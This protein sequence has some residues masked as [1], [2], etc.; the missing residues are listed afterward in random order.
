MRPYHKRFRHIDRR[1][2]NATKALFA[3]WSDATQRETKSLRWLSEVSEI[4]G[5]PTPRLKL[6]PT[7]FDHYQRDH[8]L[9]VLTKW[10]LITLLHEFRHH[11]QNTRFPCAGWMAEPD[12]RAWSLSLYHA[13][14]PRTLRRLATENQ[15]IHLTPAMANRGG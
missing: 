7:S 11:L 3:G 2:I 8:H 1:T 5:V 15:I 12:A 9:I 14:A 10:S 4:Y 6:A 13:V